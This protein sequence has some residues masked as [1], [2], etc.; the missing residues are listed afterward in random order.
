MDPL[1]QINSSIRPS[2]VVGEEAK[3][4]SV[5]Q[6]FEMFGVKKYKYK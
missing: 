5:S 1:E 2:F 3:N 4:G 6:L